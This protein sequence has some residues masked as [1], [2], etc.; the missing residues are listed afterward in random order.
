MKRFMLLSMVPMLA[1]AGAM[2]WSVTSQRGNTV[3]AQ[4][5]AAKPG[6]I[7]FVIHGGAGVIRQGSLSPARE[8]EYKAK[9]QEAYEAGYKVLEGGGKS[10][11]AVVAAI[12]VMEDSPLFNAGK[13]AVFSA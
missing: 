12:H 1:V 10:L 7:A 8:A 2:V 4:A 3:M 6:K 9:L 13:G 11:D 5:Q